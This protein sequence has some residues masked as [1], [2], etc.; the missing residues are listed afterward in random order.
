LKSKSDDN[1]YVPVPVS[2]STIPPVRMSRQL[3]GAYTMDESENH[4]YMKDS[5]GMTRDWRQCGPA[6]K[7]PF[8]TLYGNEVRNLL[9]AGR[10]ISV[11]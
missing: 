11:Y 5:I 9:A 8:G 7:I 4:V 1:T 10:D 3:V 2:I 6:F